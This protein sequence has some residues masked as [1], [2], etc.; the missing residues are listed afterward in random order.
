MVTNDSY[1]ETANFDI[2]MTL[3]VSPH[4][5]FQ[6]PPAEL[7]QVPELL[8]HDIK[9]DGRILCSQ[10]GIVEPLLQAM[11]GHAH[12]YPDE[13]I[14]LAKLAMKMKEIHLAWRVL[15]IAR[16]SETSSDEAVRRVASEIL[17]RLGDWWDKTLK[18]TVHD[19][20]GKNM[21]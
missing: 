1:R 7:A 14:K 10:T 3:G 13:F 19:H 11:L 21:S 9:G 17:A 18:V 5:L 12:S 8:F 4:L 16:A 6:P 15:T 20:L 2:F